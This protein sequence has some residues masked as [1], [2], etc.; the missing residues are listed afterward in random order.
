MQ[1]TTDEIRK[2]MLLYAVTDQSWLKEGQSLLSVCEDVLANG[3]TFL[4]LREKDLD[5]NAFEVEAAK[6]KDLCARHKVPYV[7]NDSVE[8][9]L[10]IDADGV[11]VGQSDIKGRDIRSMIGTGKILGISAGTVEEAIAAENFEGAAALRD[12]IKN[13][14]ENKGKECEV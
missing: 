9:A 7:V 14:E 8:I 2:G 4:Q 11:H 12:E 10:A 6:L 3:A 1:F 13:L 5:A